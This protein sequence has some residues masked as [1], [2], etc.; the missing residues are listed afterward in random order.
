MITPAPQ[1]LTPQVRKEMLARA[2][3]YDALADFATV[4]TLKQ[5]WAQQ[6]KEL[7][8]RAGNS[9]RIKP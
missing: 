9:R 5:A 6:A 1:L 4:A 2:I 8:E 3:Q 7:R